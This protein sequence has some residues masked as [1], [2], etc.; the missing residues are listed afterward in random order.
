MQLV[1]RIF[2]SAQR[3][4]RSSMRLGLLI[5]GLAAATTVRAG[6]LAVIDGF[7]GPLAGLA[8]GR[9]GELLIADQ[10]IGIVP[11][12]GGKAGVPIVLPGVTDVS[13]DPYGTSMWAV[14]GAGGPPPEGPQNDT[15]QGLHVISHGEVRKVAN[16]FQFEA[17]YNPHTAASRNLPDS[18]PYDVHALGPNAALVVDA[19]G[20]DLLRI[21]RSGNIK[22]LAVFPDRVAARS[23]PVTSGRASAS[24]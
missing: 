11:V 16:L 23:T 14:T 13:A 22:V 18:N 1:Q 21:D 4:N 8:A 6:D 20:N 7:A 15:G 5:F 9:H 10:S 24:R 12:R 3:T 19:G 17:A 2:R